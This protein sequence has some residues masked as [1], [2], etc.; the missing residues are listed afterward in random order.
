MH[1]KIVDHPTLYRDMNS[2]HIVQTDTSLVRKHQARTAAIEEAKKLKD[3]VAAIKSD[4]D[5]IKK[6][7]ERIASSGSGVAGYPPFSFGGVKNHG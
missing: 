5:E 2:Q 6:M 4:I 1:A 3:E 7:L